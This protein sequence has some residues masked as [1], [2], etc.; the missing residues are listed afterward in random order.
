[1]IQ[2]VRSEVQYL[3]FFLSSPDDPDDHPGLESTFA[4]CIYLVSLFYAS[5]T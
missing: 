2:Y 4:M 1:M 3:H 5:I